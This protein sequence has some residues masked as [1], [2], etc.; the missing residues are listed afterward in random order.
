[1]DLLDLEAGFKVSFD[2]LEKARNNLFE[3]TETVIAAQEALEASRTLAIIEN[4]FD[5]KNAE[6][7]AAQEAHYFQSVIDELSA[8]REAERKARYD[9]EWAQARL[10]LQRYRLRIAEIAAK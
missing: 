4:R 10:D 7:R 6:I 9:F 5:G 2:L 1:M 3:K 8:H